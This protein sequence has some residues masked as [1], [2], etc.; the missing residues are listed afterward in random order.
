LVGCGPKNRHRPTSGC[1]LTNQFPDL[2]HTLAQVVIWRD[3]VSEKQFVQVEESEVPQVQTAISTICSKLNMPRPGL[4]FV[5]C[6]KRIRSRTFVRDV[7]LWFGGGGGGGGGLL[8]VLGG[9]ATCLPR[10]LITSSPCAALRWLLSVVFALS[11]PCRWMNE[12]SFK[13]KPHTQRARQIGNPVRGVM[14]RGIRS[15]QYDQFLLY[16]VDTPLSTSRP[17]CVCVCMRLCVSVFVSKHTLLFCE[18]VLVCVFNE[19]LV[20]V[21]MLEV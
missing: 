20:V 15:L 9:G 6:E 2:P 10:S 1:H 3:G 18:S 14:V 5:I 17:V 16:S 13:T 19:A 8:G 21:F 12:C 11:L 7:S 4:S